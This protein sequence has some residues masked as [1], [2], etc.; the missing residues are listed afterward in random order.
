MDSI[1]TALERPKEAI[2]SRLG[3][4]LEDGSV[5]DTI[6]KLNRP[7][8]VRQRIILPLTE[9]DLAQKHGVTTPRQS[10]SSALRDGKTHF[11]RAI[12]GVL[13]WWYIEISPGTLAADGADRVAAN[14]KNVMEKA[15]NLTKQ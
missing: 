10:Y 8:I 5:W 2:S 1:R 13:Q 12:A 7:A 6:F 9:P 15:V 4:R 11:G 3:A 14:L